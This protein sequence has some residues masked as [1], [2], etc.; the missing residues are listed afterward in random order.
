MASLEGLVALRKDETHYLIF[1]VRDGQAWLVPSPDIAQRN[2]WSME[3]IPLVDE[4]LI[5]RLPLVGRVDQVDAVRCGSVPI[6]IGG[7]RNVKAEDSLSAASL[8]MATY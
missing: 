5:R 2:G 1:L 7:T 6:E 8:F 3:N 4:R